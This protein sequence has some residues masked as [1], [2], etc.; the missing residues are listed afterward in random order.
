M[1]DKTH[2]IWNFRFVNQI[3][4]SMADGVFTM[5]ANGR[6]SLWNRSMERISGYTAR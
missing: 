2:E 6:I 3:I 4:D 1:Q 5:D